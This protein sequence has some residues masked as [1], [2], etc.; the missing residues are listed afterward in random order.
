M[1]VDTTAQS[2]RDT[3]GFQ[4]EKKTRRNRIRI[5]MNIKYLLGTPIGF[6]YVYIFVNKIKYNSVLQDNCTMKTGTKV[7]Y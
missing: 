7:D 5:I 3:K 6:L 2:L 1:R 4:T